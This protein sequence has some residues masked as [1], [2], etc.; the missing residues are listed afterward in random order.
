MLCQFCKR[1]THG[2]E[3][4]TPAIRIEVCGPCRWP[5][6][7]TR[8]SCGRVKRLRSGQ[9]STCI[10]IRSIRAAIESRE[11]Q[12]VTLKEHLVAAEARR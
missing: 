8:C 4:S 9:C 2:T 5:K 11:R 10:E 12:I 3:G 7:Y 6:V 1:E